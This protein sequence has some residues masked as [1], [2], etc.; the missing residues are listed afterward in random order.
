MADELT[1]LER[2]QALED[3]IDNPVRKAYYQQFGES[4]YADAEFLNLLRDALID[5]Y[6]NGGGSGGGGTINQD[7]KTIVKRLSVRDATI[8]T[9]VEKINT[10]A[11]FEITEIDS[12]LFVIHVREFGQSALVYKYQLVNKGKGMYGMGGTQLVT[13]DLELL[14][15]TPPTVAD[16]EDPT[17]VTVNFGVLTGQT[18][19]QWLN[20]RSPSIT[21]QP[22][23]AGYTLFKGTVDGVV[24]SYLF[25]G[26]AGRY[27][28][29]YL[30]S[31]MTDFEKL[32]GT[33]STLVLGDTS[34]KAYPGDKGKTAYDHSQSTGNPHGT[35]MVDV[36]NLV[37]WLT[38]RLIGSRATDADIQVTVLPTTQNRFIDSIR[39]FNWWNW[40]KTQV[41]TI[42]GLWNFTNGITVPTASQSSVTTKVANEI[43]VQAAVAAL[44]LNLTYIRVFSQ[45][46]PVGAG[47]VTDTIIGNYPL[48]LGMFI[49]GE[50]ELDARF[51]AETGVGTEVKTFR[52]YLGTNNNSLVSATEIGRVQITTTQG[53]TSLMRKHTIY[54][55]LLTGFPFDRNA[56]TD[57]AASNGAYSGGSMIIDNTL[58]YY[59]MTTVAKGAT[60]TAKQQKFSYKYFKS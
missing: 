38:D 20:A 2:L 1:I 55:G 27:G 9:A 58:Q 5:I 59:L 44:N 46:I 30:I 42:S 56:P 6:E 32:S 23:D 57:A 31:A 41:T 45:P 12:F 39:L 16:Y 22:Q 52:F 25:I 15:A 29:G 18:I 40:I 34:D 50:W 10:A 35:T 53:Y 7:N 60:Q 3:K 43:Y 24:T 8:A 14:Y 36:P 54:N 17:T 48:P 13:T 26:I 4:N 51:E 21:I 47:S 11:A 37:T 19:S 49:N 33:S 28:T